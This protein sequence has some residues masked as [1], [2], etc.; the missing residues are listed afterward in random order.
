MTVR[1]RGFLGGVLVMVKHAAKQQPD[2]Y[3][4]KGNRP[5]ANVNALVLGS[6]FHCSYLLG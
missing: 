3:G 5:E 2:Q 1:T 4:N 6:Y